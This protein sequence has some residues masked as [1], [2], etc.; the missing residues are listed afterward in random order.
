MWVPKV[1]V[2][3]ART[4]GPSTP[5]GVDV[6]TR[7]HVDRHDRHPGEPLEDGHGVGPQPGPAADADDAVHEQVGTGVQVVEVAGRPAARRPECGQARAVGAVGEQERLDAGTAGRE[8][9]ARP[10]R[11]AAV[12][13]RSDE[14]QDAAPVAAAEQVED[15]GR[16][17]RRRALHERPVGQVRHRGGLGPAYVVDGVRAEH[18]LSSPG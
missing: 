13:A 15:R 10:Q 6:D 7:G 4:C 1:T 11:V 3:A 18:G 5:S 8:P 9:S 17:T 2:R 14:Q 16:E 12:V